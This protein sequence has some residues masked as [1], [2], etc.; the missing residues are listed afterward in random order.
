MHVAWGQ[1][2]PRQVRGAFLTLGDAN[3]HTARQHRLQHEPRQIICRQAN[4]SFKRHRGTHE[5]TGKQQRD[6]WAEQ[7]WAGSEGMDGQLM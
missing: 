2:P 3:R 4:S 6:G 1:L 5:Q 7:G